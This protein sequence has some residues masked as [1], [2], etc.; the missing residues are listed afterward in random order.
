MKKKTEEIER[1]E[2]KNSINGHMTTIIVYQEYN[3]IDFLSDGDGYWMSTLEFAVDIDG[4]KI[5]VRDN[6]YFTLNDEELIRI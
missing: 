3:W 1:F 6:K 2:A 5:N 4:N